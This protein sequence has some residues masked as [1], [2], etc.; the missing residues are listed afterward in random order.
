MITRFTFMHLSLAYGAAFCIFHIL[1]IMTLLASYNEKPLSFLHL[2]YIYD[3]YFF[4]FVF[5]FF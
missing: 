5:H 2:F 4:I 1:I 3:F